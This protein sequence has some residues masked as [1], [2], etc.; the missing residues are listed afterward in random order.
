MKNKVAFLYLYE[1]IRLILILFFS[2]KLM[3]YFTGTG[4]ENVEGL[5]MVTISLV[6]GII[7][8]FSQIVLNLNNKESTNID[9]F[10]KQI[11]NSLIIF[12]APLIL[13]YFMT[14]GE[15]EI[16]SDFLPFTS[17]L[18]VTNIFLSGLYRTQLK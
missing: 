10:K 17:I 13:V 3:Q 7:N 4:K 12:F 16:F 14:G 15:K 9:F 5:V 6:S 2:I 8:F 11:V 18:I 1:I